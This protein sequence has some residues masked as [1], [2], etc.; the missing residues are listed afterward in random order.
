MA[1][2]QQAEA[3]LEQHPS[4][5]NLLLAL[6]RLCRRQQLWGKARSYL[7]ASLSVWASAIAHIELAR[8]LTALE[9]SEAAQRHFEAAASEIEAALARKGE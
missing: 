6:G 5:P 9:E 7:E 1:R 3:W 8:L 4:D 2:I